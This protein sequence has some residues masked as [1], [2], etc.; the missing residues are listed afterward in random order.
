M[1]ISKRKSQIPL[2]KVRSL[3]ERGTTE[4]NSRKYLT[5]KKND[6]FCRPNEWAL[7]FTFRRPNSWWPFH[8]LVDI[9]AWLFASCFFFFVYGTSQICFVLYG[10]NK[11][12]SAECNDQQILFWFSY[13]TRTRVSLHGQRNNGMFHRFNAYAKTKQKEF[14][15]L[16]RFVCIK[17]EGNYLCFFFG[18][19]KVNFSSFLYSYFGFK[20]RTRWF[21]ATEPNKMLNF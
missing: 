12:S 21:L 15:V 11:V 10:E 6:F 1:A 17:F 7:M 9:G 2:N 20:A 3:A 18:Y 8:G 19:D 13:I 4:Y 14:F 16:P 5:K